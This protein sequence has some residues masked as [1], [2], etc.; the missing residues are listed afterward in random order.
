MTGPDAQ[1]GDLDATPP[2]PHLRD[3]L[4]EALAE[5][6]GSD[7]CTKYYDVPGSAPGRRYADALMPVIA[8]EVDAR[9]QAAANQKAAEEL[10]ESLGIA[11]TRGP[12]DAVA[13]MA[14]RHAALAQPAPGKT[15]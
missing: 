8:A 1:R 2:G 9:V 13:W 7:D 3:Q 12:L 6:L 11:A 5:L 14:R 10:G 15:T 4:A